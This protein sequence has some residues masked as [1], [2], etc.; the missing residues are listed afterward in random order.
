[1]FPDRF[2]VLKQERERLLQQGVL[3]GLPTQVNLA[4]RNSSDSDSGPGDE[5][6]KV[7][8]RDSDSDS[9]EEATPAKRTLFENEEPE[10]SVGGISKLVEFCSKDIK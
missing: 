2:R 5:S 6:N 7:R 4:A 1:M 3:D 9:G 8:K 10:S